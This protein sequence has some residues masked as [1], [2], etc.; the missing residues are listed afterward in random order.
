MR[1]FAWL[2]VLAL[3]VA[4]C[5]GDSPKD[6][7]CA[8]DLYD[9]CNTEHDCMSQN[10]LPFGTF[11]ACTQACTPGDDT[12]CPKQNGKTVTCTATA[13]CQPPAANT[14]VLK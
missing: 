8:G 5:S 7:S 3:E 14:C 4:A 9:P 10:C 6:N 2:F 1:S 12:T 13:V 11:T